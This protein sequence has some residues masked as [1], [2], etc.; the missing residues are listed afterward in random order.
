[1]ETKIK[2]NLKIISR[3]LAVLL[4]I[5]LLMTNLAIFSASANGETFTLKVGETRTISTR[6]R[7]LVSGGYITIL[8]DTFYWSSNDPNIQVISSY[9]STC[10][11]KAVRPTTFSSGAIIEGR[12]Q[13][14]QIN[15]ITNIP[16]IINSSVYFKIVTEGTDGSDSSNDTFGDTDTTETDSST[17]RPATPSG[18]ILGDADNDGEINVKDA[19]Y[20]QLY[21]ANLLSKNEINL[22][23]CDVDNDGEINVKDA[24]YIQLQLANLI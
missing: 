12:Y 5:V 24:T 20:I 15:P 22:S 16:Y 8:Y 23:V 11:I 7:D 9:G 2:V 18:K 17:T 13:Y 10:T 14:Q 21:L 4:A 3:P 19:T 1:M 6:S